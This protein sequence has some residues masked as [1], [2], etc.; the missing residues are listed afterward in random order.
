VNGFNVV[1]QQCI[2]IYDS[3]CQICCNCSIPKPC[4]EVPAHQST[5][6]QIN[7]IPKPITLYW[8]LGLTVLLLNGEC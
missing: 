5:M 7:R 8:H 3:G 1:Y 2:A 6:M 4:F